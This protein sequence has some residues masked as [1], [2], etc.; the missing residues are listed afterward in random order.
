MS[1]NDSGSRVIAGS[2]VAS[3]DASKPVAKTMLVDENG[4]DLEAMQ[5]MIKKQAEM[6]AELSNLVKTRDDEDADI[7]RK[8]I[9]QKTKRWDQPFKMDELANFEKDELD[10]LHQ[11]VCR[12]GKVNLSEIDE[13]PQQTLVKAARKFPKITRDSN[14]YNTNHHSFQIGGKQ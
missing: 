2:P 1:P 10:D 3:N 5:D 14:P 7:T 13:V 11:F 8:L 6:I 12:V 4:V 9:L